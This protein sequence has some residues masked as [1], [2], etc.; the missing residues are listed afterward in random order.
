M[1]KPDYQNSLT[2]LS[3]SILL[4]F[5]VTPFHSS[6]KKIDERLKGSKKIVLFLFD[7]MGKYI[8]ERHL[9]ETDFLRKNIFCD[10]TSTFA[11]TTVA[12][13]N[14]LLSGKFPI[15]TGWLGWCQYFQDLDKNIDVFP[16]IDEATGKYVGNENQM[17][18]I[19]SY[20]SIINLINEQ[21]H[22]EVAFDM[23]GFPVDKNHFYAKFMPLFIK[24]AYKNAHKEE[25]TFVYAYWVN[26]DGLMHR[27]GVGAKIVHKNIL[28]INRLIEKYS[29]KNKD[30]TTIVIADHGLLDVTFLDLREHQ[31]LINLLK[32]PMSLE[33][34]CANFYVKDNKVAEFIDLFKKYY[35]HDFEI[36]TK[37]QILDMKLYGDDKACQLSLDFLGDC[38]AIATGKYAINDNDKKP[39]LAHHGGATLDEYMISVNIIN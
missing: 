31:D 21:W 33:R 29:Q 27:N 4:H 16:N 11:P 28:K 26:P 8:I 35:P 3:N 24:K 20:K 34:R 22:K 14:S 1:N 2:N 30:V 9:K 13:T 38:V 19:A 18:K 6:I 39:H 12:A 37:Q 25:E 5:G 23:K 32:R 10:I 15:E 7:G 36:Y 17:L